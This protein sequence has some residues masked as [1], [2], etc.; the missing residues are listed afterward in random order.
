MERTSNIEWCESVTHAYRHTGSVAE[1][2]NTVSNLI[3]VVL[4]AAGL[5]RALRLTRPLPALVFTEAMLIVVGLGSMWFHATRSYNGEIFGAWL[6]GRLQCSGAHISH[7]KF[8]KH[9]HPAH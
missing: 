5:F 3:F 8:M 6:H 4:G 1:L 7:S 2:A 9:D